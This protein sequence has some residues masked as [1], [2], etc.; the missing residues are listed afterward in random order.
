MSECMDQDTIDLHRCQVQPQGNAM[1]SC[2]LKIAHSDLAESIVAKG[3]L[4]LVNG[5]LQ[6]GLKCF[7]E[8]LK[9]E[10]NKA[11]LYYVQGL[12]LF[13]YG[14][15]YGQPKILLAA[16]KKFKNAT[17]LSPDY[18]DVWQA[19]GS[20]LLKLGTIYNEHHYFQEAQKKIVRAIALSLAQSS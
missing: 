11:K 19:W 7:D 5:D 10:F 8:A 9:L 17:A 12:S 18:F 13:E 2:S 6:E 4:A 14:E 20:V 16:S 3:Q 15:K 1:P